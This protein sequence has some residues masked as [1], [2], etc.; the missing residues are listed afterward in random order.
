M[1]ISINGIQGNQTQFTETL[2]TRVNSNLFPSENMRRREYPKIKTKQIFACKI[3][4][5]DNRLAS[6]TRS[7]KSR[8]SSSCAGY[9]GS[10]LLEI[11]VAL[12]TLENVPSLNNTC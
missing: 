6:L 1:Q 8:T 10:F 4:I 9:S 2:R 7:S 5:I 11:L 12:T 3:T